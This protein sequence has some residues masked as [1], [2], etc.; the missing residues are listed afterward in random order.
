MYYNLWNIDIRK[1]QIVPQI[2]EH[3]KGNMAVGF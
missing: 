1:V 3:L 2:R